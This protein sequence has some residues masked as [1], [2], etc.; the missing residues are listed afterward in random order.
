MVY[1]D[2][3]SEIENLKIG[4]VLK[5]NEKQLKYILELLSHADESTNLVIL[6]HRPKTTK[7]NTLIICTFCINFCFSL[8]KVVCFVVM[9]F[10]AW[11]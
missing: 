4:H 9:V 11:K 5:V 2:V 10:T 6:H 8:L 7:Y 1:P 3:A